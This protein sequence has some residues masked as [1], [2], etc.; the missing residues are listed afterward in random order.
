MV[1]DPDVIFFVNAGA[2]LSLKGV[3]CSMSAKEIYGRN[4]SCYTARSG[5]TCF[6][7]FLT[8]MRMSFEN[9]SDWCKTEIPGSSLIV[10]KSQEDQGNVTRFIYEQALESETIITDARKLS[11]SE[12]RKW[13]WV[14]GHRNIPTGKKSLHIP[15]QIV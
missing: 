2:W 6:T 5:R 11:A 13:S 8:K 15:K 1:C 4:T 14:N 12:S 7:K 10:I 9:A 3:Q